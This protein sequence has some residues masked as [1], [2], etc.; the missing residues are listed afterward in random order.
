MEMAAIKK[1]ME[2]NPPRVDPFNPREYAGWSYVEL[3]NAPPQPWIEKRAGVPNGRKLNEKLKSRI[4]DAEYSLSMY[5]PPGYEQGTQR[6]WLVLAFD[7]GFRRMD[8][9]LDN[10][11]AAEKIPPLVVV[12]V[13]NISSQTRTRDL[14]CSDPFAS[15]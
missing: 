13:Q 9:T 15:F 14:N 12:G 3:P 7:G 10:L 11:L 5:T 2:D 6:C 4:L 1:V 8:V